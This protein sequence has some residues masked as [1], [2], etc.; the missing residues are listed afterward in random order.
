MSA[1]DTEHIVDD[2]ERALAP[3]RVFVRQT[4]LPGGLI[5]VY[6]VLVFHRGE[7]EPECTFMAPDWPTAQTEAD[8]T[9][10]AL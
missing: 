5:R 8:R 4:S 3:R 1:L 7:A 10:R 9:A 2:L 6:A